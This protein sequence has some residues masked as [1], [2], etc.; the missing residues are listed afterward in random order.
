MK[1]DCKDLKN[2]YKYNSKLLDKLIKDTKFKFER[3]NIEKSSKDPKEL[4][5]IINNKLGKIKKANKIIDYIYANKN[6]IV[7]KEDIPNLDTYFC[8]VGANLSK[9]IKHPSNVCVKPIVRNTKTIFIRPTNTFKI[10]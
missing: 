3:N 8:E 9:N 7:N 5:K 2:E 10:K 1:P 4:W 6:K